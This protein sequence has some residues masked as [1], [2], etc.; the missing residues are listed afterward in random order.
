M[1]RFISLLSFIIQY[2]NKDIIKVLKNKFFTGF[3]LINQYYKQKDKNLFT[4][5]FIMYQKKIF[6][7][8]N[9]NRRYF[10]STAFALHDKK[11]EST[12]SQILL[13]S[14]KNNLAINEVNAIAKNFFEF[15]V[16]YNKLFAADFLKD[17]W[18][19]EE[20]KLA[21]YPTLRDIR[22]FIFL[23][24]TVFILLTKSLFLEKLNCRDFFI[25]ENFTKLQNKQED[26]LCL[27]EFLD[28]QKLTY[29]FNNLNIINKY[30][31]RYLLAYTE[32]GFSSVDLNIIAA[33]SAYASI[34]LFLD[35][36]KKNL[37]DLINRLEQKKDF[38]QKS[39]F[40]LSLHIK[41][42]PLFLIHVSKTFSYIN[43]PIELVSYL[44]FD[45]YIAI[46]YVE[47]T[48][49]LLYQFIKLNKFQFDVTISGNTEFFF[50]KKKKILG[51]WSKNYNV[52][53]DFII[54]CLEN[55]LK[56]K[57]INTFQ[58]LKELIDVE[59]N[60]KKKIF[61]ET[62]FPLFY[63]VLLYLKLDF[64]AFIQ[65]FFYRDCQLVKLLNH[66]NISFL[67]YN[68]YTDK[69]T[70]Q[71]S[72]APFG[73][74]DYAEVDDMH[75]FFCYFSNEENTN[76][77]EKKALSQKSNLY[78]KRLGFPQLI[79]QEFRNFNNIMFI[80]KKQLQS[81]FFESLIEIFPTLLKDVEKR[82]YN[83]F[84]LRRSSKIFF[85]PKPII[86][87]NLNIVFSQLSGKIKKKTGYSLTFH[88]YSLINKKKALEEFIIT[89]INAS[90][91][92]FLSNNQRENDIDLFVEKFTEIDNSFISKKNKYIETFSTINGDVNDLF[93]PYRLIDLLI[94][95]LYPN[96]ELGNIIQTRRLIV[97]NFKK[98]NFLTDRRR[99]TLP[100]HL[101]NDL[102]N[103]FQV[104]FDRKDT[105]KL[106]GLVGIRLKSSILH[107]LFNKN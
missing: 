38:Q 45:K 64:F 13:S 48:F 23:N 29:L 59:I 52:S 49:D 50:K 57:D 19:K 33:T 36:L 35:D 93:L 75:S 14:E 89:E 9:S 53:E 99:Y 96:F 3:F 94:K 54:F 18:E 74:L 76:V 67:D 6:F 107:F 97:K 106:T 24:P 47:D 88:E 31:K 39:L 46:E 20:S 79:E 41:S 61:P 42:N 8:K 40:H 71:N 55:Y 103:T 86:E 78:L 30:F 77:V 92:N 32:N 60:F 98:K 63:D 25:D 85:L 2:I 5:N 101:V 62:R 10:H 21:E 12:D 91:T 69:T 37:K 43:L 51:E 105:T 58:P 90:N 28:L 16:K 80:I 17:W 82:C 72:F 56:G 81:A 4:E 68:A 73:L 11:D 95:K 26:F 44:T 27:I 65:S 83:L 7:S 15:F 22:Q 104:S 1:A 84:Y 66:N 70:T 34:D 87:N 100:L 102:K